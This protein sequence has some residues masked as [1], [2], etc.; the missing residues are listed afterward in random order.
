M[1][2]TKY[3]DADINDLLRQKNIKETDTSWKQQM[4]GDIKL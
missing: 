4:V 2:K 3:S 1:T